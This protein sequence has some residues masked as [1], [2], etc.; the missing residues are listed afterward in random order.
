[1]PK[2]SFIVPIWI[3]DQETLDLTN[4]ALLSFKIACPDAEFILVD[5]NSTLGGGMLRD[6]ASIYIK[7]N[8]NLGYTLAVNQG[9]KLATG[10][11][12]AVCNNDILI[13]DNW[14]KVAEE[15]LRDPTVAVLHFRVC[16]YHEFGLIPYGTG[17]AKTGKER[18]CTNS[19]FAT[20]K[21]F[22]NKFRRLEEDGE[23]ELYP[24]LFDENFG[25]GIYD[26]Y[27][28]HWR[29]D[30]AGFKQ[31]YT[32]KAYYTHKFTHSFGKMSPE[33]YQAL[34]KKNLEYFVKKFGKEPEELF[35]ERWPEQWRQN[36]QT[37]FKIS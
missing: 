2:V 12:I 17:I 15:V 28:W 14:I 11:I 18:W 26:D 31:A 35:K 20:T 7:N 6:L 9:L 13:S 32:D 1:M 34:V 5:N 16:H 22:L 25:K 21:V 10:E 33:D 30:Q 3:T 8:Q 19:F 29:I 23:K 24:G 4:A 27:S 37:G 36:Y